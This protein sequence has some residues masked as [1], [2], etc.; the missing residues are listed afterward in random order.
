MIEF[1]EIQSKVYKDG[2]MNIIFN[3]LVIIGCIMVIYGM[4]ILI[5]FKKKIFEPK[6]VPL[7]D[8]F[9][10]C[11]N[12]HF[13]RYFMELNRDNLQP[14]LDHYSDWLIKENV[15]Y[16][17]EIEMREARKK[18]LAKKLSSLT[19]IGKKKAE[20]LSGYAESMS[21]LKAMNLSRIK[22]ISE[23]DEETIKNA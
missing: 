8:R 10:V 15:R 3:S 16:D 14:N 12:D 22:G 6:K 1:F 2:S 11:Y 23:S 19:G 4:I 21:E 9:F 7:F 5:F 17:R 18:E 20:L 13:V